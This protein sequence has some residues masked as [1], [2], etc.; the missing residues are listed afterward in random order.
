MTFHTEQPALFPTRISGRYLSTTS[1]HRRHFPAFSP[2]TRHGPAPFAHCARPPSPTNRHGAGRSLNGQESA[3]HHL[4]L[5]RLS[6]PTEPCSRRP[7]APHTHARPR[8][9]QARQARPSAMRKQLPNL[10]DRR[11]RGPPDCHA[12]AL[13]FRSD[14]FDFHDLQK[15]GKRAKLLY[16]LNRVFSFFH[17]HTRD[18]SIEFRHPKLSHMQ[19]SRVSSWA[20]D[21]AEPGPHEPIECSTKLVSMLL[22]G[23]LT[24]AEDTPARR[25]CM[26]PSCRVTWSV[27]V[28]VR[29]DVRWTRVRGRGGGSGS[30]SA[31]VT[32]RVHQSEVQ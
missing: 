11:H 27:R 20:L 24:G 17:T 30:V 32:K 10:V 22:V 5:G 6:N 29:M 28:A 14:F 21:A 1:Y 3:L 16:T 23:R 12:A 13:C 7:T 19:S 31:S 26:P 9:S 18:S 4:A 15:V 8:Y 25:G 2:T